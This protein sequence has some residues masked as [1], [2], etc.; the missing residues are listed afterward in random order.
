MKYYIVLFFISSCLFASSQ[1]IANQYPNMGSEQLAAL[2]ESLSRNTVTSSEPIN[3]KQLQKQSPGLK[4]SIEEFLV[5]VRENLQEEL[6][7]IENERIEREVSNLRERL[8][9]MSVGVDALDFRNEYDSV[10]PKDIAEL[11][12]EGLV[13]FYKE[14]AFKRV[15]SLV[16]LFF[17]LTHEMENAR[18]S[19][20]KLKA[21]ALAGEAFRAVAEIY[22]IA[23]KTKG[24]VETQTYNSLFGSLA[25]TI[26]LVGGGELAESGPLKTNL[27]ASAAGL[28]LSTLLDHFP[29][30]RN[31]KPLTFNL[32]G[33]SYWNRKSSSRSIRTTTL[34]GR[35][36]A[37]K[38]FHDRRYVEGQ[39]NPAEWAEFSRISAAHESSFRLLRIIDFASG[40]NLSDVLNGSASCVLLFR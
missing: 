22:L 2:R 28:F 5:A 35:F 21:E 11:N 39:Q 23:G 33:V 36:E 8:Y 18:L 37:R 10:R 9:R 38:G 19:Q 24:S 13:N 4:Q 15:D 27:L 16:A 30:M 25:I 31:Y 40:R 7:E 17:E 26:L 1:A 3:I 20:D 34:R 6:G 14:H 32:P 29:K 12:E